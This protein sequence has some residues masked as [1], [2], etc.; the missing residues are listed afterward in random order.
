MIAPEDFRVE[1]VPVHYKSD[2]TTEYEVQLR[3]TAKIDAKGFHG[4]A[5]PDCKK[6]IPLEVPLRDEV[7]VLSVRDDEKEAN[8]LAAQAREDFKSIVSK[9]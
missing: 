6:R 2:G 5:C 1:V 4:V 9:W 3:W 8:R 7:V